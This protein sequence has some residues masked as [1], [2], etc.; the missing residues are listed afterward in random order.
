MI[1]P[2]LKYSDLKEKIRLAKMQKIIR[3]AEKRAF[4]NKIKKMLKILE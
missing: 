3:Y 4:I 1:Y 2:L